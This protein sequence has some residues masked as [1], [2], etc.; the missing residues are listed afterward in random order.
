MAGAERD[1]QGVG[2]VGQ[3]PDAK[4][5]VVQADGDFNRLSGGGL[6]GHG[7]HG[8]DAAL[9]RVGPVRDLTAAAQDFS[10]VVA[11]LAQLGPVQA[12]AAPA[13]EPKIPGDA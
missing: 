10:A 6:H 7:G 11:L 8:L 12:H 4:S 2:P 13:V 1:V 5:L 3:V 9:V